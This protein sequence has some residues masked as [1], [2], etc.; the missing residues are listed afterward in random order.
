LKTTNVAA[1]PRPFS[2]STARYLISAAVATAIA[3]SLS[4]QRAVAADD[5]QL[6]EVTIT[7]SRIARSRDLEAPS[8]IAT[9]SKD[10]FENS[11]STSMEH[12]LNSL[13]QFVP[14]NNQFTSGIQASPTNSP[15]SA[16]VN[17]RGLGTNRNLV[18]VDGRRPQ[19]ANATLAVDINT[20]PAAAIKSVEVITGGASAVYGPDAIAGVVNFVLKDDFQG[21]DIDVQRS[22]TFESDGGETHV[23]ALMGLN[24]MDDR[25]N[26]MVGI[27]WNKRDA[28]FQNNRDFYRNGWLDPGNPSGGFLVG[29]AYSP[30]TLPPSQAALDS[31]FPGGNVGVATQI[32]FNADGTPYVAA[33]G[34][35]YNGPL[36]SLEYG[37]Y[38]AIKKLNNQT[39]NPNTLDQAFTQGYASVPLE[40][41]SI[42]GRGTFNF[43]DDISAFAQ[44][45][46]S[47]VKVKTRGG[48][49]PA[50]TIWQASVPRYAED[51]G[52]LPASLLTLLNSRTKVV[53]GATVSAAGDPWALYQVLDYEGP[54]RVDN[55]TDVWQALAGLKGKLPFRDWTWEAY[56]SRGNTHTQADYDGLPSLQRYQYLVGLPNFGKGAS[57]KSPPGTPFGYGVTCTSGL[58]VFQQFTPSADCLASIADPMKTETDLRQNIVEASLQGGLFPL[59]AGEVRF[60]FGAGYRKNDFAFSPGNPVG[61]IT[62]NPVGLF[63]S[64]Y[65]NGS[66]NVKEAFTEFLIPIVKNLDL[67]LGYRYSDFNTAGGTNTYKGLFTWKAVEGISFRGGYQA[68]TR[69]P[70][71]AELFTG[72]TQ[73]V[74]P[75][76]QEDPCSSSTLAPWGNVPSNPN[77]QKVQ[78]LCRQLI[79]NSTSEFDTQTF[80]TPSGPNGWTRQ[81]PKFF[82]LEIEVNTGNPEVKP[83]TGRT[84]TLGTVISNPFGLE[85]FTTTLDFYRIKM[86]DTI[87]PQSSITVYNNCFNYDGAS[88]PNY[89]VNNP[90]CKLIARDPITGDRATVIALYKNLGTLLTQGIDLSVNWAH[91]LGP[92]QVSIGTSINYLQKYEYQTSPTSPLVDAKGTLDTAG[93]AASFGGLYDWRATSQF[94]YSWN[95]LTVGLN[96]I[97]LP[98]IKDASAATNPST[99]I[100]P[101]SSYDLFN[102]MAT[103]GF[104]RYSVRVGIDNLLDKDPLIVGANPGVTTSSSTTNTG[105]YDVLGRR[106]SVGVKASF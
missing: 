46:Y 66:T 74:V 59:P 91:D 60:S 53:N 36:N 43:T 23:S 22:Q 52:Y 98:S 93:G 20:I 44:V 42:F 19:P 26:I 49:P 88:N 8:P 70:N 27:D 5:D 29:P 96:W 76:P 105:F 15:G 81:N 86:S 9:V 47:N 64:N 87:A 6:A 61:A 103:Y 75:F 82:P 85:K 11:A 84:W 33:N 65:T 94:G 50:I 77:R 101:V 25:G 35:G 28:V 62:D 100:K 63:A 1:S 55:V 68:A 37:R 79:G 83:E 48:L 39:S 51:A 16:T 92:G 106:F 7:G 13:P 21:L 12:V 4:P 40:R 18:L 99:T 89:D 45:N 58:P 78:T 72:A 10:A 2:A 14:G 34:L 73:N 104:D 90:N 31:L 54:V 41:H 69:A 80:N 17:L 38:M 71:V 3:A 97:H 95:G 30:G 102:L 24:G 67:E 56:V 32:N 57:V